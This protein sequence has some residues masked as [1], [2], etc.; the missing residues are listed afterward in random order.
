MPYAKVQGVTLGGSGLWT[1]VA[2]SYQAGRY[3]YHWLDI[4]IA[5]IHLFI[6]HRSW[7]DIVL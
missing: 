2:C 3:V 1:D 6:N 5:V 7:P 4:I